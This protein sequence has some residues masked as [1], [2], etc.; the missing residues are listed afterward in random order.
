MTTNDKIDLPEAPRRLCK[1]DVCVSCL[2]LYAAAVDGV[3]PAT[4]DRFKT[5]V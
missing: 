1:F 4:R 3:V 5:S 2:L